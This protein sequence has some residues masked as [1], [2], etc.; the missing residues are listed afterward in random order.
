MY[1]S[2]PPAIPC[3][4]ARLDQTPTC[5]APGQIRIQR[6][7]SRNPKDKHRYQNSP[8]VFTDRVASYAVGN[9]TRLKGCILFDGSD[10]V[11]STRSITATDTPK[12]SP[13]TSR[14]G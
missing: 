13:V 6:N 1:R 5:N 7:P 3:A 9:G 10:A 12:I 11:C 2:R 4:Y 8:L 14:T